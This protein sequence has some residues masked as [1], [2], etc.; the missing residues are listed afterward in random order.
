MLL[1]EL[2]WATC[3]GCFS[4]DKATVTFLEGLFPPL[5]YTATTSH[6][7]VTPLSAVTSV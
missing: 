6:E 2:Q 4:F 3:V 7:Y 1:F 5:E